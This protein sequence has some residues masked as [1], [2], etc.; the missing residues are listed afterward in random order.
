MEEEVSLAHIS[1]IGDILSISSYRYVI[2]EFLH[3]L[4][5]KKGDFFPYHG[6]C[7]YG[8]FAISVNRIETRTSFP[9][10]SSLRDFYQTGRQVI[11]QASHRFSPNPHCLDGQYCM[12]RSGSSGSFT[13]VPQKSSKRYS[14]FSKHFNLPKDL[15]L[16]SISCLEPSCLK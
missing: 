13:N 12:G 11:A 5:N 9:Y 10:Y 7:P 14:I 2:V 16:C 8:S 1:H 15:I 4:K 6:L 3:L